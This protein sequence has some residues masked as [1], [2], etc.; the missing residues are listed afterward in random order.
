MIARDMHRL[1]IPFTLLNESNTEPYPAWG[2]DDTGRLFIRCECG[3]LCRLSPK[4]IVWENGDL[5]RPVYHSC[6]N[7]FKCKLDDWIGIVYQ[8]E[9]I[10]R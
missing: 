6:G 9:T 5:N 8:D 2:F 3:S 1:L 4:H 10:D 7:V